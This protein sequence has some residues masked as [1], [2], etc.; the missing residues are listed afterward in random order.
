MLLFDNLLWLLK[1]KLLLSHLSL[2]FLYN[3]LGHLVQVVVTR[4]LWS[5]S[6]HHLFHF[7]YL[8]KVFLLVLLYIRILV[9]QILDLTCE[10]ADLII[11]IEMLASKTSKF[12]RVL[13]LS[14]ALALLSSQFLLERLN[15]TVFLLHGIPLPFEI[16]RKRVDLQPHG[17]ELAH[18]LLLTNWVTLH[19][20]V[21]EKH[22]RCF[23]G[24]QWVEG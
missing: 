19:A 5:A 21:L 15:H 9:L 2:K 4:Y 12:L 22:S 10:L 1:I 13:N 17:L 24:L 8:L 18:E 23:L 16:F 14:L 7:L 11:F 6:V 20:W 3:L